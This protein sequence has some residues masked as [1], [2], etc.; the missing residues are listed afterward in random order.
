MSAS[1]AT[2]LEQLDKAIASV[3]QAFAKR[4]R[5]LQQQQQEL[6][7]QCEIERVKNQTATK[8]LTAT[9]AQLETYLQRTG[10][11]N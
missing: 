11:G 8:E 1:L 3:D 10:T 5:T 7:N 2:A 6:A 9:I 4:L